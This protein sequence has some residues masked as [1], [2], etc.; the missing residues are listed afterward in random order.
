MPRAA[1]VHP[2]AAHRT[3]PYES[4]IILRPCCYRDDRRALGGARVGAGGQ[5]G[6]QSWAGWRPAKRLPREG[7]G[8]GCVRAEEIRQEAEMLCGIFREDSGNRQAQLT[9]DGFGDI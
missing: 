1:C 4:S 9:S 8:G 6:E 5:I 2:P 7:A 3:D